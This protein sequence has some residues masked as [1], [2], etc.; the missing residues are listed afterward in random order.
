[1][2]IRSPI[3]PMFGHLPA[4][5][6]HAI[7]TGSWL[8]R[9]ALTDPRRLRRYAAACC[10][11][12]VALATA[13]VAAIAARTVHTARIVHNARPHLPDARRVPYP[14]LAW[15]LQISGSQYVPLAWADIAGWSEDDHLQAYKAFRVSCR[16]IA[17]QRSLPADPKA[18]GISLRDPCRAARA[19]DI[20]NGAKAKAFFEQHF[21]PLRISRLRHDAPLVP[22]H[23]PPPPTP[24]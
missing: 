1:M 9:E 19:L 21:L 24:P 8:A 18:L 12:A 20:S 17:A 2:R 11:I 23:P 16:P 13:P 15:P 5:P 14:R 22:P 3:L 4:T 10:V 7:R 6:P